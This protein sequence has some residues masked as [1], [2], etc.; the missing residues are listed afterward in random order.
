MWSGLYRACT[1]LHSVK[2]VEDIEFCVVEQLPGLEVWFQRASDVVRK[3]KY[4]DVDLGIVGYDMFSE[5]GGNDPD[6]VVIHDALNFGHCHL[7]LGIPNTM[8]YADIS[9]FDELRSMQLAGGKRW[10]STTPLRV[11][12][13][14]PN[15]AQ[16]FFENKKFEHYV[17]LSADGALE[18]APAMGSAD[19]ILDLVST[20]VTLRENNL[21]EI[22][23]GAVSAL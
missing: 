4:G 2:A 13:G 1:S 23:G 3:I 19:I 10:T 8:P 18:A 7:S 17:L 14:Y 16:R 21:K 15:I 22:E 11:V 9:T 5:Y 6:L 12:T 20:G